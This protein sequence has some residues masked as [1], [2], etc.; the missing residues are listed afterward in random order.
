MEQS[1][2][3][4]ILFDWDNTL[5]NTWP[6]ITDA[7]N[8]TRA[9]YGL[10]TWTIEEARVKS[11]RALRESFPEWFGTE[12]ENARDIFYGHFAKVH[13]E[14]LQ[15]MPGAGALCASLRR[16]GIPLFIVSNKKSQYLHDEIKHLGWESFFIKVVGAGEAPKDKPDR[17]VVDI[18][19]LGSEF[20][21]DDPAIWLVGDTY[22]DVL[23]AQAAGLTPVLMHDS[24]IAQQ[25]NVKIFFS[26][27]HTMETA[28]N[29]QLN[30]IGHRRWPQSVLGT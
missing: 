10:E 15:E 26:D 17:A 30:S 14:K 11:A 19:L 22:P 21:A 28:L 18:A 27:C 29:N 13:C 23:C 4:A 25:F 6:V 8:V 24:S 3:K 16:L 7:L 2:P 1:L 5:V 12:W 20:H 9:T